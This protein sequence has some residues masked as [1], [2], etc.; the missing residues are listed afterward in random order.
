MTAGERFSIVCLSSQDWHVD[1]PTNRQQIMRAAARRGHRVLFVETGSFIGRH[2]WALARGPRKSLAQRIFTTEEVVPGICVRKAVNLLPWGHKF[3]FPNAVNTALTAARLRSAVAKLPRPVVFWI[4]DPC[5]AKLASSSPNAFAVYDCVDDYP[6]QAG[7]DALRR[8]FVAAAD[9]QAAKLSRLVFATTDPLYDRH[10]RINPDTYLVPN[11]GDYRH[12]LSASDRSSTA[13]EVEG[14]PRPV[15]GFAGNLVTT[16]VDFALLEA[17]AVARPEWTLLLVGPARPDS[18]GILERLS[19]LPNVH[20]IGPRPY[21]ELPRYVAAF[22]VALIPYALNAYT[23]SCFPLKLY[24]YL[25]AGKPVVVSG[26]PQLEGL[27]PDVLVA[28]G[29]ADFVSA[30]ETAL[31][32][33][34]EEERARRTS[35]AAKNTWETRTDRLLGLVAEQLRA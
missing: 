26:L 24:E 10:R 33:R 17:V 16:K 2:L 18:A 30:V 15:L 21:E 28:D 20:S 23:R 5:A 8:A 14:L 11:V 31:A 32:M 7:P 22:D 35:L 1:L 6:E 29:A 27:E 34:G 3:R 13:P 25:A 12:F 9:E 19:E 4:Y